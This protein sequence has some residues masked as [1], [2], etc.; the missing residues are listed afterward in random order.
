MSINKPDI[1]ASRNMLAR[2]LLVFGSNIAIS[3]SKRD[4]SKPQVEIKIEKFSRLL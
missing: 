1:Q 4:I 2:P 3:L